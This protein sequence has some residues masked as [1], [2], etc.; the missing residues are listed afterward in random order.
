[1]AG[2]LGLARAGI[3][4]SDC[5]GAPWRLEDHMA[6]SELGHRCSDPELSLWASPDCSSSSLW[7]LCVS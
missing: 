4:R 5:G 3:G 7:A 2:V 6:V 1:M